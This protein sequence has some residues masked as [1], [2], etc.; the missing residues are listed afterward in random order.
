[1]IYGDI[2]V[3]ISHEELDRTF[4]YKIPEHL[5]EEVSIGRCV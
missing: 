4:Q 1:M 5:L 2:I 3:D